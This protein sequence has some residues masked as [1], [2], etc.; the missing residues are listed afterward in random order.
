[1]LDSG[2]PEEVT[3]DEVSSHF[4]YSSGGKFKNGQ[5]LYGAFFP[6][7]TLRPVQLSVFRIQFLTDDKVWELGDEFV[8]P[9]GDSAIKARADIQVRVFRSQKL[10]VE[11]SEPPP[12]HADVLGWAEPSP[13]F[14]GMSNTQI[15]KITWQE[16]TTELAR[17]AKLVVR[18][19]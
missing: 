2:L 13:P 4:F 5:V 8:G 9:R 10:T 19:V 1:M 16:V 7:V 11:A 6:P 17:K 18:G 14:E 3:D 15:A 12:R